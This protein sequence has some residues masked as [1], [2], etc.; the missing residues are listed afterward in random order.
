MLITGT[1][2]QTAKMT[3]YEKWAITLSIL[4][5][6]I[7]IIQWVWR[8]WISKPVLRHLPTGRAF[9][10]INRSGSYIQIEGVY[11]AENK[12]ISVKNI[13]LQVIRKQDNSMLNLSWSTF[14][15]PVN[16]K[17]VGNYTS[18]S[19]IAHP[20]RI[21]A[22]NVV[23]AFTEFS[24]FYDSSAK[25]FQPYYATLVKDAQK[26]IKSEI[27]FEQAYNE[28]IELNSYK[29][30]K[31]FLEKILFWEIGKYETI[32][33]VEYNTRKAFFK[34]TFDVSKEDYEHLIS[35][36]NE[37]ILSPLKDAYVI[38]Y[39]FQMVKVELCTE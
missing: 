28:Y 39:A 10:F 21:D 15:S 17:F 29:E 5:I 35:N 9:L 8:R 27:S 18:T 37:T 38:P 3:T 6:L 32:L 7:P 22:N 11:E 25:M 26:L 31:A 36:L 1:K 23:C 4:A 20:F 16:Q 33:E 19:E 14:T 30:A 24:D 2:V 13:N 12:P 34:Y